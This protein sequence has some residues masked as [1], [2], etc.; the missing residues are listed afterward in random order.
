MAVTV[1]RQAGFY[2]TVPCSHA[3]KDL[4]MRKGPSLGLGKGWRPHSQVPSFLWTEKCQGGDHWITSSAPGAFLELRRKPGFLQMGKH[5]LLARREGN[6][7]PAD[8]TSGKTVRNT[9]NFSV[10]WRL[11]Q[12]R[13]LRRDITFQHMATPLNALTER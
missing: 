4:F 11:F 1:S 13:K 9:C 2:W 7:G 6:E 3:D 8:T 12:D 5:V 10:S